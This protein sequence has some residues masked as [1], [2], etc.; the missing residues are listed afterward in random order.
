M[1]AARKADARKA[2]ASMPAPHLQHHHIVL[3]DALWGSKRGCMEATFGF[4]VQP[5][6]PACSAPSPGRRGAS[7]TERPRTLGTLR[8]HHRTPAF[9]TP[10]A[11]VLDRASLASRSSIPPPPPTTGRSRHHRTNPLRI[12]APTQPT[13]PGAPPPPPSKT[14]MTD[15][16]LAVPPAPAAPK[17]TKHHH[18]HKKKHRPPPPP[19]SAPVEDIEDYLLPL[20]EWGHPAATLHRPT[21]HP[22]TGSVVVLKKKE[23]GGGGGGGEASKNK[24]EEEEEDDSEKPPAVPGTQKLWVKTFGKIG[25]PPTH[26]PTLFVSSNTLLPLPPKRKKE[27]VNQPTEPPTSPGCSHNVSDS[28]YME[29]LLSSYGYTLLPEEQRDQAA[30]WLINSCT[31]KNPSQAGTYLPP[32]PPPFTPSSSLLQPTHPPTDHPL[33]H[34]PIRL[35]THPTTPKQA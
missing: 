3:G 26:P 9:D 22:S 13:N 34:L 15:S 27:L 18:H 28:E 32:P 12:R 20:D 19:P 8:Q 14:K 10:H 6:Y 33:I 16:D 1:E 21:V 23:L 11:F 31:V 35:P 5:E 7:P 2:H 4:L 30:L 17:P 29:G 24:E 25:H